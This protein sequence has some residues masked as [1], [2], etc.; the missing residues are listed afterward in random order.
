M[1]KWSYC[2]IFTACNKS[3]FCYM[4]YLMVEFISCFS[5][6]RAG[7][8]EMSLFINGKKI[9]V[10]RVMILLAKLSEHLLIF[11]ALPIEI[12]KCIYNVGAKITFSMTGF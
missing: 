11:L 3:L 7:T 5:Q 1:F 9:L 2:T 4:F 10:Q 6:S 8:L 12:L